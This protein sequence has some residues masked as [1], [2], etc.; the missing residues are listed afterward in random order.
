[1]TRKDAGRASEV[2]GLRA[3]NRAYMARQLMIERSP[4]PVADAI[5]HLVGLQ[6]QVPLV[7]YTSLWSRLDGF[8][9]AELGR[10]VAD[11]S[12]VR[13]SLMRSHDP[14]GHRA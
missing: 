9:P 5:E 11:R 4:M 7:P 14:S 12:V 8:D 6:G 10:L 13:T 1:M 3:I 2:L